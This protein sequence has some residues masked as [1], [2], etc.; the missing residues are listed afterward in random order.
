MCLGVPSR[1]L[2]I[3]DGLLPMARVDTAG[4]QQDCSLGYH[5]DVQVG[6]WV[7]VQHGLVVDVMDEVAARQ[8]WDAL[9]ELGII[10]PEASSA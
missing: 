9:A 7:L 10:P 4:Q 6:D 3:T 1:V 5:D 8:A 2:S